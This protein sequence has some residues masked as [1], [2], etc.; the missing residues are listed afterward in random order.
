MD[1]KTNTEE[2]LKKEK[3]VKKI[4]IDEIVSKVELK[5]LELE[6]LEKVFERLCKNYLI[7]YN[8]R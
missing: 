2:S 4:S 6:R 5:H 7:N 8:N 1:T 3:I